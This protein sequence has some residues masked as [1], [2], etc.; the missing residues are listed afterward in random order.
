MGGSTRRQ[1]LSAVR[2]QAPSLADAF[3]LLAAPI[4]SDVD[5]DRQQISAA[6]ADRIAQ[7]KQAVP[8]LDASPVDANANELLHL[9]ARERDEAQRRHVQA[10]RKA[11]GSAAA[12]RAKRAVAAL[13]A[14]VELA[15]LLQDRQ[16]KKPDGPARSQQRNR[17]NKPGTVPGTALGLGS[18]LPAGLGKVGREAGTALQHN[19]YSAS[20]FDPSKNLETQAR[21]ATPEQLQASQQALRQARGGS[22]SR[23]DAKLAAL[24]SA[25]GRELAKKRGAEGKGDRYARKHYGVTSAQLLERDALPDRLS[26]NAGSPNAAQRQVDDMV[27]QRNAAPEPQPPP[28]ASVGL[29]APVC[30]NRPP[31]RLRGVRTGSRAERIAA[32]TSYAQGRQNQR[33]RAS[34]T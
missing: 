24:D 20:H 21:D 15:G 31:S 22:S 27:A 29:P 25:V 7:A 17:R 6:I 8:E 11:T 26:R 3:Q 2:V 30:A 33:K 32:Q 16:A 10:S 9:L 19:V 13:N 14:A 12:V 5:S 1:Q 34:L 28:P 23:L 4:G 18:E